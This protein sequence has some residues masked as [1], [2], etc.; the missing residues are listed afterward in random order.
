MLRKDSLRV[1]R[2]ITL[3][4]RTRA[5]RMFWRFGI[6][7]SA[8]GALVAIASQLGTIAALLTVSAWRSAAGGTS[9][10]FHVV[11]TILVGYL[12]NG[13]IRALREPLD[14]GLPGGPRP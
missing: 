1:A 11:T 9:L 5:E 7:I 4:G 8:F 6:L 2:F 10:A 12:V 3:T 14:T 13:F